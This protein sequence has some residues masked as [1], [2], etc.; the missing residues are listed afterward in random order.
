[1]PEKV[2]S[3]ISVD[4]TERNLVERLVGV[5]QAL[6]RAGVDL[7]MVEPENLHLTLR[8]LGEIDIQTLDAVSEVV[9]SIGL[10]P[11]N[12]S[13]RGVGA[14][15]NLRRINT[16]WVGVVEGEENLRGLSV[17]LEPGLRRIGFQPDPKGFSPHLTVARVKT[18][19]NRDRLASLIEELSEYEAGSM[20]VNS[21][22]LKR[23][24]L[25]PKGPT[26]S[27]ILEVGAGG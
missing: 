3:F 14:F 20:T 5:Q 4:V 12:V 21:V 9:K 25:T 13:F 22:R 19:K 15:P 10:T 11:F 23:S 1:L 27:T 16:V 18:G 6:T 7:K 24:V 2:R 8:F 26:Y 17:K